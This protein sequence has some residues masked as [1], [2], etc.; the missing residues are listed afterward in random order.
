MADRRRKSEP[1]R[2]PLYVIDASALLAAFLPEEEWEAEAD[3]LWM[4][5]KRG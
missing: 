5:I 1:E 4:L 2:A 3:A